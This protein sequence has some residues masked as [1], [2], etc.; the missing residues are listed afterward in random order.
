VLKNAPAPQPSLQAVLAS[1]EQGVALSDSVNDNKL[2]G[3]LTAGFN[4]LT[5]IPQNMVGLSQACC[6]HSSCR[7]PTPSL[8]ATIAFSSATFCPQF[9]DAVSVLHGWPIKLAQ[10]LWHAWWGRAASVQAFGELRR[11]NLVSAVAEDD[12]DVLQVHDVVRS[13]G[14]GILRDPQ[15]KTLDGTRVYGSRLWETGGSKFLS[16]TKVSPP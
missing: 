3:V 11:R 13:L 2:R 6:Q 16:W 5:R 15:Y 7:E 10:E 1:L 14:Q 9:L 12:E 8:I 4:T